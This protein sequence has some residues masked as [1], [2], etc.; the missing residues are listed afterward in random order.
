M[1]LYVTNLYGIS[2]YSAA[3]QSQHMVADLLR[4][5]F[6]A[7]ELGIY[8]YDRT[9]E[10]DEQ[11]TTRFD[12]ILAS[13]P[14]GGNATVVFQSPTW[15]D[16]Q[17]ET[18]LANRIRYAYDDNLI[19]FL[20]DV[21]SL[22]FANDPESINDY[23]RLY[24][25]ANAIIVP[26]TNMANWLKEKG[27]TVKNIVIQEMWDQPIQI[28]GESPRPQLNRL[29]SFASDINL[30]KFDFIDELAQANIR[31][32]CFAEDKH[33]F[34][35]PN[36][37]YAGHYD[38]DELIKKLRRDGGFGLVWG[39]NTSD[40]HWRDYMHYNC[41]SKMSTYLAA[42][43]PVIVPDNAGQAETVRKH[44]LGIVAN[45]LTD[46]VNQINAITPEQYQQLSQSIEKYAQLVRGGWFTRKA[47][48][49]A[50]YKIYTE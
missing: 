17:W 11:L 43:L 1:E 39:I 10:S 50:L 34:D 8:V 48:T 42:G 37:I 5:S 15:N 28:F 41:S 38:E 24:N 26:T 22:Q 12:G 45:S 7:K 9:G 6:S 31:L 3:T 20:E 19:M 47:I 16:I 27:L 21:P 44:N 35:N 36:I 4:D 18:E 46:A 40:S 49:E 13:L 25:L 23:I 29:I 2:H 32:Q 14:Y 33:K 30:D